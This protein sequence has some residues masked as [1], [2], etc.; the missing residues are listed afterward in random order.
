M[1]E[2]GGNLTEGLKDACTRDNI[3]IVKLMITK[4]AIISDE[5]IQI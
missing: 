5:C 3:D 1:I 4:G 2:K